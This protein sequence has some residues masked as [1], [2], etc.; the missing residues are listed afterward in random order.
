MREGARRLG[1]NEGTRHAFGG[2]IFDLA[3]LRRII[4][5]QRHDRWRAGAPVDVGPILCRDLDDAVLRISL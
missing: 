4:L 5:L 1:A 3:R 2:L